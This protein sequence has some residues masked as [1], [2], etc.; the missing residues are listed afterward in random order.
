MKLIDLAT[1][2][3]AYVDM[4]IVSSLTGVVTT[5]CASSVKDTNEAE[6]QI[7]KSCQPLSDHQML[8]II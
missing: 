3:D 6:Y 7:I 8:V 1:V 4:I 2:L 5:M